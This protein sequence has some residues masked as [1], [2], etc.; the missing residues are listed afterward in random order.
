MKVF[1]TL[2]QIYIGTAFLHWHDFFTLAL[3]F[4]IG[5]TFLSTMKMHETNIPRSILD[6]TSS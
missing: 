6:L 4:Y 1:S 5:T 2:Y 3:L